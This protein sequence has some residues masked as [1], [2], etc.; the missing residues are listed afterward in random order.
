MKKNPEQCQVVVA[1]D[2][3]VGKWKPIIIQH[4]LSGD[5][6]RFN[7][8]RRLMPDITQRMLTLHL[9]ELE[10]QDIVQRVVYPQIPPKV[11][12]SITEYGKSLGPI[13][14]AMHYW[15]A[16]HVE[17]MKHKKEQEDSSFNGE[18]N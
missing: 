12:Y 6:L 13:M 17:H 8:L 9:R 16:A 4:L 14:D 15:G 1:L 2:M 10:E 5:I 18:A 3:I 11:E 7:E